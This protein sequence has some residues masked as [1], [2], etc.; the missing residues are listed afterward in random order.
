MANRIKVAIASLILT[1]RQQGWS[2]RRIAKALGV[3]RE[4]VA[5]V[6]SAKCAD[7]NVTDEAG[8]TRLRGPSKAAAGTW[9]ICSSST[10]RRSSRGIGLPWLP[11][12]RPGKVLEQPHC[13]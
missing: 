10:G 12:F 8:R 4:T 7:V 11:S 9:S 13:R 1:L 2:F 6:L 5:E 3:H